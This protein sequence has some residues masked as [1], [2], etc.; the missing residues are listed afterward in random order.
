MFGGALMLHN[1]YTRVQ[2]TSRYTNWLAIRKPREPLCNG[3]AGNKEHR[4]AM[5]QPD[6]E[7]EDANLNFTILREELCWDGGSPS[8]RYDNGSRERMDRS[9]IRSCLC[10]LT[11]KLVSQMRSS[12]DR[13][14]ESD[15]LILNVS[16]V[17]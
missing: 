14:T 7:C 2:E 12:V 15:S 13:G 10:R 8:R 4:L 1:I 16:N 9:R 11:H 17:M 3:D 5:H 6:P